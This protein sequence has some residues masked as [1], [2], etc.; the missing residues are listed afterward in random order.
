MEKFNYLRNMVNMLIIGTL[1]GVH[2]MINWPEIT[3]LYAFANQK[4]L[5]IKKREKKK[6]K[7]Y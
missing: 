3:N 2:H 7:H 1:S 5:P 6:D 4:I